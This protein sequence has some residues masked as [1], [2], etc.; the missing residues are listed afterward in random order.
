MVAA[1][2]GLTALVALLF[3]WMSVGQTRT[4][5]RIA[6]QGQIT[7][8][9]NNAVE[10]LGSKSV[11]VRLGGLYALQRIMQDS[12][13][14]QPAIVEILCAYVRQNARVPA[15]GFDKIKLDDLLDDRKDPPP[16][17]IAAVMTV[18]NNR[19]PD[20]DGKIQLNLSGIE[21]RHLGLGGVFRQATLGGADL[22]SAGLFGDLRDSYFNDANL[23]HALVD[24]AN[25][26]RASFQWATLENALVTRAKLARAD[27]TEANLRNADLSG[28]R[29]YANDL[30]EAVFF[31]TDMR[32]A[33][34]DGAKLTGAVFVEADLSGADLIGANLQGA[35][36]SA[37][38]ERLEDVLGVELDPDTHASLRN[39][40][41]TE[42]DLRGADLR[43][44]DIS[45]ADLTR[46]DLRGAKLSGVKLTGA[47]LTGVRGLP[48]SLLSQTKS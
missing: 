25:L 47:T 5:L 2:P 11:D 32:D 48:R 15:G 13:R 26:L 36:L 37:A 34:L 31:G 1:L 43:G 30:S 27:F 29:A 28:S 40:D 38:D 7:N 21:L 17:D 23:S 16:T 22:R 10:H 20:H 8:R 35:R 45:G 4:E 24:G 3:T 18:L 9:F 44:V 33:W 14:D 46:V 19:S 6:E 41:L 42:A 39:A 12:P